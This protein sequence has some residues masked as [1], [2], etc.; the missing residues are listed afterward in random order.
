VTDQNDFIDT[1]P[2]ITEVSDDGVNYTPITKK[3]ALDYSEEKTLAMFAHLGIF[4][5]L[6]TAVLGIVPPLVIYFAY[7]DRSKYVA[8]QSLQAIIFQA[9]FFIGG[10]ILAGI[11]WGISLTLSVVVVGVLCIPL[12]ILL[13]LIP[14][15]AL[16]YAIVAAV[17]SYNHRDFK[18][19]LVG[20]WVRDTYEG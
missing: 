8:Y 3:P 1:D 11:A 20:E 18:Y 14:A 19:W 16:V 9:I 5:N 17:D 13:S 2:I 7:K 15:G 12:A 6:V 10:G 4:L